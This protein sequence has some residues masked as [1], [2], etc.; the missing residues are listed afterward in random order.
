MVCDPSQNNINIPPPGPIPALPG[1]GAP[2]AVPGPP[3]PDV[4]IPDGIPEDLNDLIEKIFA[5]FPQNIKFIPNTD[6]FMKGIWDA[7]A[8][9]FNQLAPFLAL[10]NFFQALL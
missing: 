2:F 6:S 10:Y 4:Q 7:L 1:L 8:S 5:L 3:F 9:M